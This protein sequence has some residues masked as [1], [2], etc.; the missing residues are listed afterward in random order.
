MEDVVAGFEIGVGLAVLHI[1]SEAADAGDDRLAVF[2]MA[3]DFARQREKLECMLEIDVVGDRSLRQ[4]GALGLF[5]VLDS[6]A[7]LHIGTEAAAA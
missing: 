5:A 3:A 2:R 7:E 6:L 4:A 1:R